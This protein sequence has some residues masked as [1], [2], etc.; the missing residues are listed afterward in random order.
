MTGKVKSGLQPDTIL[1]H[2]GR[3]LTAHGGRAINPPVVRASTIVFDS[4]ADWAAAA[5]RRMEPDFVQYGRFGTPTHFA[6]NDAIAKLEGAHAALCLPSGLAAIVVTYL[7][8][9]GPGDHALV[10]D[11]VYA[12]NRNTCTGLLARI[13][14]ETTF[15]DPS[16]G[17]GIAELIRPNTKLIFLEAPGSLTFEM[18]DVPAI[19]E[20]A[21]ARGV[22]TAIDNTWATP[23]YFRPLEVGVDVS[24]MAGTKYVVGHSDAMLGTL[25]TTEAHYERIKK[26]S[27]ELGYAVGPDDAWLALR[28]LRTLSVRLARHHESGLEVARWLAAR[29]E[30]ARVFHPALP[31]DPGHALWKRDFSGACGLFGFELKPV[32]EA[33]VAALVDGLELFGLGASWGGYESLVLP[34]HPEKLRTAVPWDG[35]GPILRLH[36]GLE[37]P[38]D[39]IADLEAGFERLRAAG[40]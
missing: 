15:Y 21:R 36:V 29:P 34:A 19:A 14:V 23:L 11:T 37:D 9:L 39:L 38:G 10:A 40:G 6:L 20:A 26:T 16:V 33:A 25:A 8:F 5:P 7:A 17:A 27:H 31:G 13:G 1:G 18:Q 3:D 4:L 22:V 32:S 2:A 24:L 30:V 12:P 35:K 28:G